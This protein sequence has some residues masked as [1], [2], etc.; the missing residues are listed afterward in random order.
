MKSGR[1]IVMGEYGTFLPYVHAA[2]KLGLRSE[3]VRRLVDRAL[4][5]SGLE[6]ESSYETKGASFRFAGI[7]GLLSLDRNRWIEIIPKFIGETNADWR[8]DFLW[9]VGKTSSDGI[10]YSSSIPSTSAKSSSLYDVIAKIW[11]DEFEANDRKPIRKYRQQTWRSFNIDGEIQ[12]DL[13]ET[14]NEDGFLQRGIVL[15]KQTLFNALLREAAEVLLKKSTSP[16]VS[17]RLAKATT[18]LGK[19]DPKFALSAVPELP[20]RNSSWGACMNLSKII[21]STSAIGY[22]KSEGLGMP[23]F[24]VKTHVTWEMLTRQLCR[25]VFAGS[26]VSKATYDLGIRRKPGAKDGSLAV[27]PDVTVDMGNGAMLLFDA[28]YKPGGQHGSVSISNADIYES[29]A[30]MKATRCD[31]IG[32]IYPSP[33]HVDATRQLLVTETVKVGGK[34]IKAMLLGVTGISRPQGWSLLVKSF[35]QAYENSRS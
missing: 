8:E 26:S 35:R 25:S 11:C 13:T 20:S 15:T 9:V 30:F 32:L 12:G 5:S 10:N 33:E 19:R 24:I 3:E 21:V 7:S 29:L 1:F 22:G 28:K 6:P 16:Q 31:E 18:R 2:E 17:Q 27:T 14:A 4:I 23:S 34:T